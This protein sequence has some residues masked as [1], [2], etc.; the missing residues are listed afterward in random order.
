MELCVL[1]CGFCCGRDRLVFDCLVPD[2]GKDNALA[3]GVRVSDVDC[4][5]PSGRELISLR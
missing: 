2:D 4:C 3:A 1:N 5:R